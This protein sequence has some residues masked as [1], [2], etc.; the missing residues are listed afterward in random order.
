MDKRIDEIEAEIA[1]NDRRIDMFPLTL[2]DDGSLVQ[3]FVA[4]L[5]AENEA[6]E[7]EREM[8]LAYN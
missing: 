7:R 8:L 3:M 1:E 5:Q 6:L 4:K 2:A